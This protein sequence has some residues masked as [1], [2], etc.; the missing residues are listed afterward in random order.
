MADGPQSL[1][2]PHRDGLDY[3]PTSFQDIVERHSRRAEQVVVL[4]THAPAHWRDAM[5]EALIPI[6]SHGHVA[7]RNWALRI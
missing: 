2:A 4:M 7:E 5:V 6:L 1:V 3:L